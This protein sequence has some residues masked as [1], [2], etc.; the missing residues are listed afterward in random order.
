MKAHSSIL[1]RAALAAA[2]GSAASV[3]F[4]I[5]V[6]NILL[7][8]SVALLLLSGEP[9][10]MPPFRLPLA[11]FAAGTVISLLLS[12]DPSPANPQIRKFFVFL[13]LLTLCSTVTRLREVRLLVTIWAGLASLAAVWSFV[14][15]A[16]KMAE[17]A[18][19]GR[20]FYEYYVPE[21]TTGFMSHWMT[22]G[23]QQ[24]IVLLLLSA[25]IFWAP[26]R[27]WL[28]GLFLG[29]AG[30]IALSIVVGL[31]RGIWLGTAAGGF[32]LLWYW[33]RW[34]LLALPVLLGIGFLIAPGSV[35]ERFTS[36]ARPHGEVDSNMHR[37][38]TWRTGWEMIKAHPVFGLG[39][40]E[41][42]RQ[43]K[44]YVPADVPQPLPAGW[45]GHLHNIYLHYAAERGI[46][47]MLC[48]MWMLF[49]ILRDF[50]R[51]L[52]R[53]AGSLSKEKAGEAEYLLRGATAVV[54]A[55][56][57][58]GIFELNLGDSE[59]LILFLATAACGYAAA[60]A[61]A[62]EVGAHA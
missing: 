23:G 3:L 45:Y 35:R 42:N 20:N 43:F 48:L 26:M 18:R 39:P 30:L 27:T 57:V 53:L 12:E 15:F 22:F 36:A 60:E 51:A 24:M 7:A 11:L 58:T 14:Q 62:V 54:I 59:V 37:I 44:K 34:T 38:I 5:A 8:L 9:L 32:Y 10:R 19:L 13:T 56:L 41:V 1:R 46:P 21:R 25:L 52:R 50:H 29:M 55:I 31:T 2:L 6:C 4:S 49:V 47:T 17:A 16:R 40:E 28:R 33:K 61:A